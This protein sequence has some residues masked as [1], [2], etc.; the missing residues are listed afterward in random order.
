MARRYALSTDGGVGRLHDF[1][2]GYSSMS[3]LNSG[4]IAGFRL[5][6]TPVA[7]SVLAERRNRAA[8]AT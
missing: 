4:F 2:T 1:G 3:Q 7:E 6:H 5:Q 8:A